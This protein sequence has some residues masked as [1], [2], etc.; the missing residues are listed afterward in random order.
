[1]KCEKCGSSNTSV[2]YD[3]QQG[4]RQHCLECGNVVKAKI[5]KGKPK[6]DDK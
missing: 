3:G 6:Q 2:T 1:M 4:W 5:P